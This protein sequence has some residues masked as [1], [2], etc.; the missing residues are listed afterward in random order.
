MACLPAVG[1][2]K[3]ALY[4]VKYFRGEVRVLLKKSVE[5]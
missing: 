3:Y 5:Q 2:C 1:D 4:T